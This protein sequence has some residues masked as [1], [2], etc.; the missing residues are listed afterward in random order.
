[1]E[2]YNIG[3]GGPLFD[4]A[5]SD[6]AHEEMLDAEIQARKLDR[7]MGERFQYFQAD[8]GAVGLVYHSKEEDAGIVNFKKKIVADCIPVSFKGTTSRKEADPTS[9]HKARYMYAVYFTQ[10]LY[11]KK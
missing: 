11:T 1:M 10:F 9:A 4:K 6:M 2:N 7:A 8:N 3:V 5:A